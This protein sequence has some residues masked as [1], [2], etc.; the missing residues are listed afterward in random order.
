LTIKDLL[1]FLH[2]EENKSKR[3][4]EFKLREVYK[5]AITANI[6]DVFLDMKKL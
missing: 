5:V 1:K 4:N 2:I 6:F 3:I